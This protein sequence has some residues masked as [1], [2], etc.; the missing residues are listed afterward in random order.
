L[1]GEVIHIEHRKHLD[2]LRK[3]NESDFNAV[4]FRKM[5]I[6]IDLKTEKGLD[7]SK[8]LIRDSD[9]VVE[10]FRPNVMT[11]L[12]LG[13]KVICRLKPDFVMIPLSGFGATEPE[14]NFASWALIFARISGVTESIPALGRRKVFPSSNRYIKE[15]PFLLDESI[16]A[17]LY[18][19]NQP[20]G[21]YLGL[22]LLY[23]FFLGGADIWAQALYLK[24][25]F[26]VG[27]KMLTNPS[28]W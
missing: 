22:K 3:R 2:I 1:E 17:Q 25:A 24:N 12:G 13:Y 14:R 23:N 8:K 15:G 5:T 26:D 18:H 4:N 27:P 19:T 10:S 20:V 11:E 9:L 28:D 16:D 6:T 21:N 7:L